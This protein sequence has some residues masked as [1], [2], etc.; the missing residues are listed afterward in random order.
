V[1]ASAVSAGDQA[2][3]LVSCARAFAQTG[4]AP[5]FSPDRVLRSLYLREAAID[6]EEIERAAK[7]NR[8]FMG[9]RI[10]TSK[11][12]ESEMEVFQRRKIKNADV[13]EEMQPDDAVVEEDADVPA[14]IEDEMVETM[15]YDAA[16]AENGKRPEV[17]DGTLLGEQIYGGNNGDDDEEAFAQPFGWEAAIE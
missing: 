8:L 9:S 2:S 5:V 14:T 13:P 15:R 17:L 1:V 4:L 16:W 6:Q 11:K 12:W 3:N 10:L 7:P